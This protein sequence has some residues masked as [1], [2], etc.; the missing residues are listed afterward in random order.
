MNCKVYDSQANYL[1]IYN[2]EIDWYHELLK[3]RILIS[4]CSNYHGL[5]KGYY[6]IVV[7]T[8]QENQKLIEMM[9]Q[10]YFQVQK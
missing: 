8:K 6:R 1:L 3:N 10:L 5:S 4:D 9:N 7:K 2:E